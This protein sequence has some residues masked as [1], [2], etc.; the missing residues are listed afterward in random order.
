[1]VFIAFLNDSQEIGQ[2]TDAGRVIAE[3]KATIKIRV[4][5]CLKKLNK[6]RE[7]PGS[8]TGKSIARMVQRMAAFATVASKDKD[9]TDGAQS[10]SRYIEYRTTDPAA[11]IVD[12]IKV[13]EEWRNMEKMSE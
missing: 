4:R 11:K 10:K 1:M 9:Y 2:D 8:V 7:D 13:V 3:E 5:Q 12:A 6:A